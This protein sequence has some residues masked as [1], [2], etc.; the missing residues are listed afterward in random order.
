MS[1]QAEAMA[2]LRAKVAR[3]S[4]AY[5][6]VFGAGRASTE[7]KALVLADLETVC[8][9]RGGLMRASAH[10][11]VYQ[12]GKHEVW[13]R[14]TNMRFPRPADA[15]RQSEFRVNVERNGGLSHEQGEGQNGQDRAPQAG[16]GV[17]EITDD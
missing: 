13:Q 8:N 4:E 2:V 7:D 1:D 11:T 12:V 17:E 16:R 5:G 14:I 9:G 3:L 15:K 6:R 10:E